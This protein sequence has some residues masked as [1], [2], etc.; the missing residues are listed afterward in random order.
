SWPT[1]RKSL[2]A[3]QASVAGLGRSALNNA[4]EQREVSGA[5]GSSGGR[6]T[7]V[8]PTTPPPQ[9]TQHLGTD[10]TNGSISHPP[11]SQDAYDHRVGNVYTGADGTKYST[12]QGWCTSWVQFRRA[13]LG[14]PVPHGNGSEMAGNLATDSPNP[15]LGAV[16]SFGPGVG[17]TFV[18]EGVADGDP[19]TITISEM[20]SGSGP[21]P[22]LDQA[23]GITNNFGKV[24]TQTY[25]EVPPAGSGVWKDSNYG[26]I[27][28]GVTFGQ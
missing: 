1:F 10:A 4:S 3:A 14:L 5:K 28:K 21:H 15:S 11:V 19:R 24:T 9:T 7:V 26:S 8:P 13:Q 12:D 17:H 2:L 23:N 27:H 18:V 25:T 6:N 16:G 20:N 22:W